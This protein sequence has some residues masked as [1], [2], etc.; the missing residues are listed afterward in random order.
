MEYQKVLA[1]G[2][3]SERVKAKLKHLGM[4]LSDRQQ[5][6]DVEWPAVAEV[7]V[8]RPAVVRADVKQPAVARAKVER[9]V[10]ARAEVK[11]PAV[12]R[13]E[14]K[15]PVVAEADFRAAPTAVGDS[16][17]CRAVGPF[18]GD[19]ELK[20]ASA[21]LSVQNISASKVMYRLREVSRGLKTPQ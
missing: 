12:A 11:Q 7:D 20:R 2:Q 9:P 10:V 18:R 13:A 1:M 5:P 4:A 17:T 14:I 19:A 21:W 8:K 16:G 6:D 3:G 15:R